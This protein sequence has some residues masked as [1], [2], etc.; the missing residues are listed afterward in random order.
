MLSAV[1]DNELLVLSYFEASFLFCQLQP[2]LTTRNLESFKH[3]QEKELKC[4]D[5][6]FLGSFCVFW[7]TFVFYFIPPYKNKGYKCKCY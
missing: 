3:T 4:F 6:D 2:H 1:L 7:V 5:F